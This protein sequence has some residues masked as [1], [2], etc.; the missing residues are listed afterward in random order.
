MQRLNITCS[1]FTLLLLA[2]MLFTGLSAN[3]PKGPKKEVIHIGFIPLT[4]CA[5]IVMVKELGLFAKY[6]VE[7]IKEVSWANVRD[8]LLTRNWLLPIVCT[9][10]PS[11][12][13]R[14]SVA[15]PDRK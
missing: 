6:G 7:V 15:K 11:P 5:P 14:V 9:P 1:K 8:K 13:I 3:A 12:C 4:D 2:L 10:C